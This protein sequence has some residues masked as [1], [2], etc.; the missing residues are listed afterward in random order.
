[1][2]RN[3]TEAAT[4]IYHVKV[5]STFLKARSKISKFRDLF[6]ENAA[7]PTGTCMLDHI[8]FRII[9]QEWHLEI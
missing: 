3:T 9:W 7:Q 8:P 1:M 5:V 4:G 2:R 6:E